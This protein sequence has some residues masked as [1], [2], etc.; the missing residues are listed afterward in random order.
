[1][2][3]KFLLIPIQDAP[4]VRVKQQIESQQKILNFVFNERDQAV[5]LSIS[6]ADGTPVI[7]GVKIVPLF[8]ML[9]N[10]D[11]AGTGIHGVFYALPISS[12]VIPPITSPA[13]LQ[14]YYNFI[15]FYVS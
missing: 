5:Y 7:D 8:P 4:V 11:L 14:Q 13:V 6:E 9:K 3:G 15:Y 1:M 2:T 10:T 12:K